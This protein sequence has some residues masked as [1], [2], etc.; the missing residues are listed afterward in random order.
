MSRIVIALA[1]SGFSLV[2]AQ[3]PGATPAA[4]V[5]ARGV[6]GVVETRPRDRRPYPLR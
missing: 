4:S 6:R 1:L 2:V 5:F 3:S